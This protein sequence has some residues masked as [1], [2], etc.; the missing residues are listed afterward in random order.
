MNL[1]KENTMDSS[2]DLL[3][4]LFKMGAIQLS[5]RVVVAS[6]TRLRSNLDDSPSDM[7]IKHYC[8]RFSERG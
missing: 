6:I 5:H 1:P 3:F 7:M 4:S 2:H 8:Q